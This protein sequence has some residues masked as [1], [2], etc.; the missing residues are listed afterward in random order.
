MSYSGSVL[1]ANHHST[2]QDVGLLHA[3]TEENNTNIIWYSRW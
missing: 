3:I 1:A 2:G